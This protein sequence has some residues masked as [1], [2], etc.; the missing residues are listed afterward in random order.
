L[1]V[2]KQTRL[3][4]HIEYN[5]LKTIPRPPQKAANEFRP[6]TPSNITNS[7]IKFEVPG[8]LIFANVNK[9]KKIVNQGIKITR[10]P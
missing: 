5:A 6:K 9:R 7:P 3:N 1:R 2:P 10:P 8:K 4:S